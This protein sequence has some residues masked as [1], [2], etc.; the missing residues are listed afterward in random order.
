MVSKRKRCAWPGLCRNFVTSGR[1]CDEHKGHGDRHREPAPA[2]GYDA[3][4]RARRAEYLDSIAE[5]IAG[6]RVVKCESCGLE[7]H[8]TAPGVFR[9]TVGAS[10]PIEI[11]HV[12]GRG[13]RGDNSDRNLQP[14]CRS[15]HQRKTALQTRTGG[16][17]G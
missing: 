6:V 8:E 4:W 11:D 2:R 14:L 5:L 12:D 13:P 3:R 15:C 10:W 17:H 9:A 7:H 16:R 1:Y